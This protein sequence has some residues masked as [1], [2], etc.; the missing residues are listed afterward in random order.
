MAMNPVLL[1][2]V[3]ESAEKYRPESDL[4]RKVKRQVFGHYNKVTEERESWFNRRHLPPS[5]VLARLPFHD[6]EALIAHFRA[7]EMRE[8]ADAMTTGNHYKAT[9][10]RKRLARV[11]EVDTAFAEF[12]F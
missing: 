4:K 11:N 1:K 10:A 8:V 5:S 7:K 12:H 3:E 2:L 9:L 6:R